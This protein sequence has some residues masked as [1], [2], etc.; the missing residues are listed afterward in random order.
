[1]F[2]TILI[3]AGATAFLDLASA[4]RTRFFRAPPA[5]YG[6]VGRWFVHAA[7]GRIVH[8]AIAKSP[9]VKGE[10]LIGWT[11]HYAIGVAFAAALLA[12]WPDWA[13]RP[14]L[15]PAMLVGV[16]S[17][18]APFLIMQPGMGAGVAAS[19]T[20]DPNAARLRSLITHA[21]FGLGLYVAG[22]AR[23]LAFQ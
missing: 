4:L 18:L 17:V 22:V 7:R 1:M 6:L 13:S 8:E 16:G 5:N 2:T 15:I 9:A 3:G 12:A 20:P 11:A 23:L 19:R 14:T 21:L 10:R